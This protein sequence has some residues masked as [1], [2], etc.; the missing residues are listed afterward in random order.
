MIYLNESQAAE[1]VG[2]S[3]TTVHQWITRK[4][5]PLPHLRW[6]SRSVRI[7]QSELEEWLEQYRANTGTRRL[8]DIG[9]AR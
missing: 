3:K 2:V 6:G 4:R 7:I 1:Y 5:H 9:G 8:V